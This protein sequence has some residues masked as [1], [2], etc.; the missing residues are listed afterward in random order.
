M[1][2][3]NE[4]IDSQEEI[5]TKT[6]DKKDEG[7]PIMMYAVI[8]VLSILAIYGGFIMSNSSTKTR[9]RIRGRS[10]IRCNE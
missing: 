4:S 5:V 7:S 1:A 2:D 9:R 10:I 3:E 6:K 8:G